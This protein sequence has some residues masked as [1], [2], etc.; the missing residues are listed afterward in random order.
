VCF[1]LESIEPLLCNGSEISKYTGA[2]SRQRF[3]KHVPA[4]TDTHATIEVLLETVSAARSVPRSSKE[5][6]WDNEV[7]SVR[8]SEEKSSGGTEP[9]FRKDLSAVAED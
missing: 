9:S 7:S 6:N 1:V 2:V 4:T 5:D 3:H 8:E